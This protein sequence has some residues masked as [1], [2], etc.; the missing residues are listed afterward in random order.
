MKY[1]YINTGYLTTVTNGDRSITDELVSIFRK[2]A[3]DFFDRMKTLYHEGKF[4]ELGQL[5]H[6]AKSS[7]AI[8]GMEKMTEMLSHLELNA[9][10]GINTESYKVIIEAFGRDTAHALKE[11]DHYLTTL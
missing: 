8:I 6:K 3:G 7:V 2:Q 1:S 10:E 5:A 4:N 11:L 9:R